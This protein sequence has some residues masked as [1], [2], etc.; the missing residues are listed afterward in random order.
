MRPMI[1]RYPSWISSLVNSST[2]VNFEEYYKI[3]GLFAATLSGP[4][5]EEVRVSDDGHTLSI[6]PAEKKVEVMIALT[7]AWIEKFMPVWQGGANERL[8][9]QEYSLDWQ[10]DGQHWQGLFP[11]ANQPDPEGFFHFAL[12]ARHDFRPGSKPSTL[13]Q[14][15]NRSIN[16][17][18]VEMTP[19]THHV[20]EG[21]GS[22][23]TI[24][25]TDA[26]GSGGAH[27]R[28]EITNLNMSDNPAAEGAGL[29]TTLVIPYQQGPVPEHGINGV[30]IEAVVATAIHRLECFQAGPFACAANQEALEFFKAGVDAL[31]R[32][33]RDR[34]AREVEGKEVA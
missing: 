4:E 18:E 9:P 26:K 17:K 31:Q 3:S 32:R 10:Y 2:H 16:Q 28:Y 33:T 13:S 29:T 12:T 1:L 6:K 20:V 24:H 34:V 15:P 7:T 19:V 8:D 22:Q 27:H 21:A 5:P 30:T 11:K 25:A 23:L 14:F